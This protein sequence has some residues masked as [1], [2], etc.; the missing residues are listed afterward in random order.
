MVDQAEIHMKAASDEDEERRAAVGQLR[1]NFADLPDKSEA[2]DD[3]HRLTQDKDK[4]VWWRAA[5]ALG[6]AFPHVPDKKQVWEDLLRLKQDGDEDVRRRTKNMLGAVFSGI[7]D[8][9]QAWKDLIE[10]MQDKG[11]K[12]RLGAVPLLGITFPYVTWKGSIDR[13]PFHLT[14]K[15][16]IHCTLF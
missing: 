4:V 5:D 6:H 2:W 14:K 9:D 8:M 3:L 11:V 13:T 12:G 7:L 16:S 10:L 15:G 1:D